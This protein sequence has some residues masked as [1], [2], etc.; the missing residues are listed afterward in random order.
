M[1]AVQ[2]QEWQDDLPARAG[3]LSHGERPT[4]R[5]STC[6]ELQ[7]AKPETKKKR[8]IEFYLR[9]YI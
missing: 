4:H 8:K 1:V 6:G 5:L 3:K 7:E 2:W 9:L